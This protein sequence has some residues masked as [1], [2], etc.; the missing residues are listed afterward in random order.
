MEDVQ[1]TLQVTDDDVLL[2]HVRVYELANYFGVGS[3]KLYSL[4]RFQVVVG[5]QWTSGGVVD[6]IH[7]VYRSTVD[8]DCEMR[9]T[10]VEATYRYR[11]QLWGA[12]LEELVRGGGDFAVDLV[13]KMM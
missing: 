3:L 9:K 7:D 13:M 12:A 2:K 11:D 6:C 5:E 10:V 1:L 4:K 8:P